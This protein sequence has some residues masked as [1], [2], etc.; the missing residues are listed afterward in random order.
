[1]TRPSLPRIATGPP[2]STDTVG[3]S[4]ESSDRMRC[5]TTYAIRLP[6]PISCN[7]SFKRRTPNSFSSL[8]SRRKSRS[9]MLTSAVASERERDIRRRHHP[10]EQSG[11]EIP[12]VRSEPALGE[13]PEKAQT[14]KEENKSPELPRSNATERPERAFGEQ[15]K[16]HERHHRAIE[17]HRRDG[18]LG[19][20]RRA[21]GQD[22][23]GAAF[24]HHRQNGR[25]V[26]HDAAAGHVNE[27]VCC[28]QV[29]RQI[30]GQH[31]HEATEHETTPPWPL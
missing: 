21:G 1:M 7:K 5:A 23:L 4:L 17:Q 27:G 9:L 22:L 11:D 16:D 15:G 13:V 20:L 26:E 8:R 18:G 24:V 2:P 10:T 29:D 14:G 28:P 6:S 25:L 3:T 12:T 30:A 31:A 19:A